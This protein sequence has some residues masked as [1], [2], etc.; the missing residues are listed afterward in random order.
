MSK[1]FK[2]HKRRTI[3]S[4]F[5]QKKS[6]KNVQSKMTNV[7]ALNET[8]CLSV[9]N[10]LGFPTVSNNF[11][12]IIPS[13]SGQ[14]HMSYAVLFNNHQNFSFRS[15]VNKEHVT[16]NFKSG[17][18]YYIRTAL[19]ISPYSIY[20]ELREKGIPMLYI[21]LYI[22]KHA[23]LYCILLYYKSW[24]SSTSQLVHIM[25]FHRKL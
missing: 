18:V 20:T 19:C 10:L 1:I 12:V 21:M 25:L 17:S 14:N 13:L 4:S 5:F 23:L 8:K 11:L 16:D 22:I 6:C 7:S 2:L 9:T 24:G 15:W 3:L